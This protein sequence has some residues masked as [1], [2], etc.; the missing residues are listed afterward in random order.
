ME[1]WRAKLA[2]GDS[3]G[4]WDEF[5]TRYR[6]LIVATIGRTLGDDDDVGDVFA[7]ICANLSSDD[8]ARLRRHTELGTSLFSTWLV[9]VVHHQTIDWVRHRDG[10]PRMRAPAGLSPAQLRIFKRVF[11]ERRSHVEA[12]ELIRQRDEP[13]LSFADL[14]KQIA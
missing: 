3:E 10:R 4:A 7:E 11:D 9:T 1:S 14:L 6:R 13:D 5:I 8:L 2:A 12:Y